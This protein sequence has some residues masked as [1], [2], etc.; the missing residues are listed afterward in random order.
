MHAPSTDDILRAR[1]RTIGAILTV[2][3]VGLTTMFAYS[4]TKNSPWW[5]LV[6]PLLAA[7]LIAADLGNCYIWPYIY[8]RI[9]ANSWAEVYFSAPFAVLSTIVCLIT[10]FGSLNHVFGESVATAKHQNVKLDDVGAIIAKEEDNERIYVNRIAELSKNGGGWVTTTTADALRA[11]LPG[12]ELAIQQEAA[13]G[14]CKGQ[15][16]KRTQERDDVMEKIG[17]L[18]AV[19]KT[20]TMLKATREALAKYRDKRGTTER[21]ESGVMDQNAALAG[22]FTLTLEPSSTSQAWTGRSVASILVLFMVLG[23]FGFN[24]LGH[25]DGTSQPKDDSKGSPRPLPTNHVIT[26]DATDPMFKASLE[27]LAARIRSTQATA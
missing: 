27:A 12:L 24:S 22:W 8:R 2:G 25:A 20:E 5:M 26:R 23:A 9:K 15:C 7:V 4:V 16:L 19:S 10:A 13:K 3:L 14:G 18:E 1:F 17:T 21:G 6:L 11:K